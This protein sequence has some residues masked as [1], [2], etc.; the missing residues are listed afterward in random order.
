MLALQSIISLAS[1]CG[2]SASEHSAM[3]AMS[4]MPIAKMSAMNASKIDSSDHHAHHIET[5]SADVPTS[6]CCDG[7]YCSQNGCMSLSALTS[8]AFGATADSTAPYKTVAVTA[9]P[10]W[11]PSSLYRPPSA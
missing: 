10:H 4:A 1:P 9:A 8:V 5:A 6:N 3:T 11:S 7:G 2:M